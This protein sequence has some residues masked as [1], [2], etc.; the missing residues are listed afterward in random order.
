MATRSVMARRC[1]SATL[2]TSTKPELSLG[3]AG[4][5]SIRF[6]MSAQKGRHPDFGQPEEADLA[7]AHQLADRAGH[8]LDRHL[9][10]DAVLV[11]TIDMIGL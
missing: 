7:R 10:I 1:R 6:L 5:P 8:V 3:E 9:A 4:W 2:R 11:E